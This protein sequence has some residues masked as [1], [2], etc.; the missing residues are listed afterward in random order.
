M[1]RP[2]LGVNRTVPIYPA[3]GTCV[4]AS[5]DLT[6][7]PPTRR[8]AWTSTSVPSGATSAPTCVSTLRAPTSVSVW[9]DSMTSTVTAVSAGL[10]VGADFYKTNLRSE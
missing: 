3:L 4:T 7:P 10:K 2:V 5:P 9:R 1:R 8:P 6:S